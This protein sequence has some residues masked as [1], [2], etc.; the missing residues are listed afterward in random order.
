MAR[1]FAYVRVSTTGQTT[2]NQIQEIEAA[3]F[4]VEPHRIVTET[5]SGSVP[6]AQ[7]QGFSRLIDKLESGDVLIVTKLDRLGRDAIDVSSTVRNLAGLG[8][9]VYCLA[10]GGAD[11]AS[12]AGTMTMNV[13]NAVAQFERD[14][15]IERTQSGLM[16]AKKEGKVLGRPY[17]LSD[18]QKSNVREDLAKGMSVSAVARKFSTSRQT[19]M[20]IRD[21]DSPSD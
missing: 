5:V 20:R 18:S 17:S 16:R 11:L 2:E 9:K 8:I 10:L 19:I 15:L 7:R 14:L 12:S 21:E 13:L 1:T 4:N 6:I 3:G